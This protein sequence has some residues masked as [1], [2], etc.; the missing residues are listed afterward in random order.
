MAIWRSICGG[1]AIRAGRQKAKQ[2]KAEGANPQTRDGDDN[3]QNE[4]AHV[5]L[6]IQAFSIQPIRISVWNLRLNA[7]G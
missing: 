7:G 1:S 4:V 6:S 2:R 3:P 5:D